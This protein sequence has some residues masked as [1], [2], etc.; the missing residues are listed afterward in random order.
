MNGASPLG[1]RLL[2]DACVLA[3]L[4]LREALFAY[5]AEG[6]FAP[7]WSPRIE[8]EWARA[9]EKGGAPGAGALVAGDI[10]L[11]RS[12]F[13]AAATLTEAQVTA[14]E[15]DLSLP[16]WHD[17]HVLAAALLA[18]ADGIVTDNLRDFPRRTLAGHGLWAENGDA[19]A[20]RLTDLGDGAPVRRALTALGAAAADPL[21]PEALPPKL[22]A[23]RLPRFAKAVARRMG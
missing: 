17:R 8:V 22:K 11:A 19:V 10:A 23:A 9:A 1:A 21:P 7:L 16:D 14:R 6:L 4:A 5:A 12:R 3:R 18:A 13:P 20:A 15:A 2:L